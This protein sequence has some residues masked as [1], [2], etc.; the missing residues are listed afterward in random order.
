[1]I[2]EMFLS[3]SHVRVGAA[4][5]APLHEG[6]VLGVLDCLGELSN[7]RGKEV[8]VVGDLHLVNQNLL[9]AATW[10]QVKLS[11]NYL[12]NLSPE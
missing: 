12:Q 6:K 2:L 10:E 8:G 7:G 3:A 4:V 11:K 9:Q 5:A 1:M